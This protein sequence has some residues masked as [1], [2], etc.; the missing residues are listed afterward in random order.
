MT[1]RGPWL[2]VA[3]LCCLLAVAASANSA[4]G[5]YL[6]A[7]PW[8]EDGADTT[9]PLTKWQQIGAFDT[10]RVCESSRSSIVKRLGKGEKEGLDQAA[11]RYL[12]DPSSDPLHTKEGDDYARST[13]AAKRARASR[14]VS[15][16]DPRLRP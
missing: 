10:A 3:A 16:S 7:P 14:C 4:D 1:T 12:Q 5:W 9:A 6:L 2:V 11:K 15:I 13:F 8:R